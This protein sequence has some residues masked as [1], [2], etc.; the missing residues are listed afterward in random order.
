MQTKDW[1]E[2]GA[3]FEVGLF[4]YLLD[5]GYRFSTYSNTKNYCVYESADICIEKYSLSILKKKSF[6]TC[7]YNHERQIHILQ[8]LVCKKLYD[9]KLILSNT[10]RLYGFNMSY[11]DVLMYKKLKL[12]KNGRRLPISLFTSDS[13]KKFLEVQEKIYIYGTRVIAKEI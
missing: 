4:N 3:F 13:L 9:I 11:N 10:K 2:V 8:Y 6:V 7:Y 5:C 12:R 1:A